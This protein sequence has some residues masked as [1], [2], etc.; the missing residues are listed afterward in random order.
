MEYPPREIAEQRAACIENLQ[1]TIMD[2]F[3]LGLIGE[4]LEVLCEGYSAETELYFGRSFADSP[5]IDGR[6]WFTSDR[7]VAPGTF[8]PVFIGEMQD[9]DPIGAAVWGN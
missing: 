3:T 5:D 6:V 4:T 1:A 2:E 8:V 7:D 9:G